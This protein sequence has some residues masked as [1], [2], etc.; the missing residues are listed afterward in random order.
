MSVAFQELSRDF[1]KERNEHAATKKSLSQLQQAV[2]T[3]I[4][5]PE[6]QKID[7]SGVIRKFWESKLKVEIVTEPAQS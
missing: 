5:D 4:F 7:N 3:F 1:I 2:L 6:F